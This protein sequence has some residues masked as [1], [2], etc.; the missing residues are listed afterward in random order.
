MSDETLKP[1]WVG[2]N[3]VKG[4]GPARFRLLLDAFGDLKTA[5][6]ASPADLRAAGLG[7]KPV[8]ALVRLRDGVDLSLVMQKLHD[9]GINVLTWEDEGYPAR[10][11]EID[12]PPPVLYVHGSIEPNDMWAVA[13]VGTRRVTAYGRQVTSELA[14]HLAHNGVTIVSGLA[15]GVD[16]LA[17]QAA[18]NAGGRTLAVLGS[19]VDIIYPPENRKLAAGVIEHGALISDY[20]PGAGP[21]AGNFPPRNRIISGLSLAVVVVEAARESG[22]LIT[23]D[24]ALNQG[25]EVMAVPGNITAP[26]SRGTNWL[27]QQGARPVLTPGDVLDFLNLTRVTQFQQARQVLPENPMEAQLLSL[28]SLEPLHVDEICVKSNLPVNDVAANLA[29]MEL[30]GMVRQVGGM[31]YVAVREAGGEY[32]TEP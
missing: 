28:L 4:V 10:L 6:Y 18:L 21:E 1:Y 24:F 30:K 23:T 29:M 31:N 32:S 3:L 22:A 5:W 19:G 7:D 16:T 15:R 27:I 13:I 20:P 25:R 2:F 8:D 17:H 9:D 14:T 11:L 26:Q 12:A